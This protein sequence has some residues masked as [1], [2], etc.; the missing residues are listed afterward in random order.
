MDPGV[1]ISGVCL[2]YAGTVKAWNFLR[3]AYDYPQD[4]EDLMI[5]FDLERFRLHNW[6]RQAGLTKGTLHHNLLPIADLIENRLSTIEKL[7]G[8]GNKLAE[9]FCGAHAPGDQT[10]PAKGLLS[11]MTE[12]S[13]PSQDRP[14]HLDTDFQKTLDTLGL[15]PTVNQRSNLKKRIDWSLSKPKFEDLVSDLESHVNKLKD[16]LTETQQNLAAR[17][18]ER[19]SIIVVGQ[20][21]SD[22]EL[23]SIVEATRKGS[24]QA[25]A[26][27]IQSLAERKAIE[28]STKGP[29]LKILSPLNIADF[30]RPHEMSRMQ[31]F[32]SCRSGAHDP[33]HV[34][35]EKK[36]YVSNMTT[37]EKQFLKKRIDK[38]V[39]ML[40]SSSRSDHFRTLQCI[41]CIDDPGSLCWWLVFA[42]P[43]DQEGILLD[44]DNPPQ[45]VSLLARLTMKNPF[46]PPLESRLLLASKL[47]STLGSLYGSGWLHKGIRSENVL[48]FNASLNK[49]V[50]LSDSKY[51]ITEPYVAGFEYSRQ[52]TE[53][54]TIDKR[55]NVEDLQSVIYWHPDY[56]GVPAQG[57]KIQ[58]DMYSF[59]LVLVEIAWWVPLISFLD[60]ETKS[61]S[62]ELSSKM[63]HFGREQALEL[64]RRIEFRLEKEL[65]FRVGTA[66]CDVVK[67]C[68]RFGDTRSEGDPE[69]W[70][71][72]LKFYE[73]VVVPLETWSNLLNEAG[74]KG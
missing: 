50:G 65:A 12:S 51:D 55:K 74:T 70:Q 56:Q 8:N 48:F 58:N 2:A 52:D 46:K 38:L 24:Q 4:A 23:Q 62:V 44:I 53:A 13:R 69:D 21:R 60:S 42:L 72:A 16:L 7:L 68:L 67:W 39:I 15:V 31:R 11:A 66:I 47:A 57:Y 71:P 63:K 14:T 28:K 19:V 20:A 54:L 32:I 17:N 26:S 37:T 73:N 1:I 29:S 9:K 22:E 34:L 5:R 49:S 3:D 6:G 35:F 59:G 64:R 30:R 33:Q 25:T 18:W 41:G 10:I 43:V 36:A 45:P 27:T 40:G 61:K